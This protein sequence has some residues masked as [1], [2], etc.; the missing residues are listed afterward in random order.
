MTGVIMV[1]LAVHAA[2]AVLA[3]LASLAVLALLAAMAAKQQGSK[4]AVETWP[5]A[6]DW[7]M[8]NLLTF[9][10]SMNVL[11][12]GFCTMVKIKVQSLPWQ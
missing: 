11:E 2:M 7:W 9:D 3:L 12:P 10:G 5:A 8:K 4:A 1:T 6:P